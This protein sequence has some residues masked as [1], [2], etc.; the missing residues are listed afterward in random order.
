MSNRVES[1]FGGDEGVQKSGFRELC[2]EG[3]PGSRRWTSGIAH[4]LS[5]RKEAAVMVVF[6]PLNRK[7]SIIEENVI[8][9]RSQ[10]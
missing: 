4:R 8:W 6:A 9:R 5:R 2:I 7:Q 1:S 3:N 10:R